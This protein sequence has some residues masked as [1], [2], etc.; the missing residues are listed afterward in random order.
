[1]EKEKILVF[2]NKN[3]SSNNYIIEKASLDEDFIL[4][5]IEEFQYEINQNKMDLFVKIN[6][7]YVNIEN[8]KN[9]IVFSRPYNF[10]LFLEKIKES[11]INLYNKNFLFSKNI[12]LIS[13]KIYQ[14]IFFKQHD[15]PF[16][17]ITNIFKEENL[18]EYIAK[19][20]NAS[21]GENIYLY[22]EGNAFFKSIIELKSYFIEKFIKNKKDYRVMMIN[23]KSTGVVLKENKNNQIIN[24]TTGAIFSKVNFPKLE[25]IS[26]NIVDILDLD[27]CGIDFI[28]DENENIY[29]LEINF[30][31]KFEGYEQAY[32]EGIV[33]NEIKKYFNNIE[34]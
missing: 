14:H 20:N 13:N 25:Q 30:F 18:N 1:M 2:I 27:Y 4:T 8:F 10:Q 5:D 26:K 9:I 19:H 34:R 28:E 6:N 22:T 12:N 3:N 17:P 31:S 21:C 7:K 23:K 33:L 24:F 29:V 15:I 11:N 32:G 16:L